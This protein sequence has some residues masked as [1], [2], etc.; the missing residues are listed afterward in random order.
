M[1]NEIT[2]KI[3]LS[4]EDRD[5][6]RSAVTTIATALGTEAPTEEKKPAKKAAKKPAAKKPDD[7][8]EPEPEEEEDETPEGPT[9]E[10]VRAKLKEYAAIESKEAAI[11]IL[12]KH[13][14]PSI[15]ELEEDQFQA[16]IDA[17]A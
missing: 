10:E 4:E 15:G 14:A 3:E 17:C 12:N 16:V 11:A 2:I 7:G 9:R 13:G 8:P 1:S 5:L 6:L